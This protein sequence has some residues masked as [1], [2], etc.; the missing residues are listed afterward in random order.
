MICADVCID[1]YEENDSLSINICDEYDFPLHVV[2]IPPHLQWWYIQLSSEVKDAFGP[3]FLFPAA[4]I[5]DW[6]RDQEAVLKK[7]WFWT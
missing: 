7:A 1:T 5:D 2:Q 4:F 6:R 3:F